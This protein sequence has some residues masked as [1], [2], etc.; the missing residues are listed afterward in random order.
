[1][2]VYEVVFASEAHSASG[3]GHI[4]RCIAYAAHFQRLGISV[5][6]YGRNDFDWIQQ[7]ISNHSFSSI[8]DN[9]ECELLIIDSYNLDFV[10]NTR[11]KVTHKHLIQIADP[12][13]PLIQTSG[14]I[15]LDPYPP[16][17][18]IMDR[19][20]IL[21]EGFSF[22]PP[23]FS[24][25]S[26]IQAAQEEQVLVTLGGSP[27]KKHIESLLR[28]TN[29]PI[30]ADVTFNCFFS[31]PPDVSVVD[32][33]I[34]LGV[35]SQLDLMVDTCSTVISGAGTSVWDFLVAG[36]LV[37]VLKL[38][39]N[40]ENNY[41]FITSKNFAL[42]LG[43]MSEKN[44]MDSDSLFTLLVDKEK[45]SQLRQHISSQIDNRGAVRLAEILLG[46]LKRP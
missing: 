21:A 13:T 36:K 32:N 17:R 23:R 44:E 4:M 1:M 39:E 24:S 16:D 35:G 28:V 22:M 25:R 41:R 7:V 38:V 42:A 18:S 12:S 14:V 20:R 9:D 27:N 29:D 40:Q 15:W 46:E 2:A 6:L 8:D 45:R 3:A 43:D 5:G 10:L 33:H 11:R 26:N 34:F 31:K 19:H 30:F 37:G